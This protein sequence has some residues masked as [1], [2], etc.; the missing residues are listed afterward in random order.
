MLFFI[1]D[2]SQSPKVSFLRVD[3]VEGGGMNE[4]KKKKIRR[5]K[6]RDG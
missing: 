2:F 3:E 5:L 4:R 1:V 6:E